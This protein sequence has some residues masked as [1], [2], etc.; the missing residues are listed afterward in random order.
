M[1]PFFRV[2]PAINDCFFRASCTSHHQS[3]SELFFDGLIFRDTRHL[4][5]CSYFV[6]LWHVALLRRKRASSLLHR[7]SCTPLAVVSCMLL[8]CKH[9]S[10]SF[11]DLRIMLISCRLY[12]DG[13]FVKRK[14]L[15]YG[16]MWAGTGTLSISCS[17]Q[18]ALAYNGYR[19]SRTCLPTGYQ[20]MS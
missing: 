10:P 6:S 15:A 19:S 11:N 2:F 9:S 7:E 5:D 14:G 3:R 20:R 4:R 13:W 8:A 16:I 12:L 1:P 17:F 18:R